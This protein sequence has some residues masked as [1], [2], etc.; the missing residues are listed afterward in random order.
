MVRFLPAVVSTALLLG[1]HRAELPEATNAGAALEAAALARGLVRDPALVDPVGAFAGETDRVCIVPREDGYTI[2][3][4]VDYGEGQGCVARG[5][6][7]GRAKLEVRLSE[8]C[9]FTAALD[10]D[11]IVF[12]ALLPA[13]CDRTCRGRASLST[14]SAE[15]LSASEAEARSLPAPDGQVLCG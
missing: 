3:A 14:L 15:R 11:R 4:A 7:Q 6:A 12:P 5:T 1:C 8:D 9:R 10:G 13:G 2:G